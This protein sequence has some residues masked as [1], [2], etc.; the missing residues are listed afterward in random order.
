MSRK[1]S[2]ILMK[3]LR[4]RFSA[5]KWRMWTWQ[6]NEEGS[7]QILEIH[8]DGMTHHSIWNP[9]NER[10]FLTDLFHVDRYLRSSLTWLIEHQVLTLQTRQVQTSLILI[11]EL[12]L[13]INCLEMNFRN[14]HTMALKK[15]F[16]AGLT[17][18]ITRTWLI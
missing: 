15:M 1:W 11:M 9:Q 2:L 17:L 4:T 18:T 5:I 13:Q 10:S 6:V 8:Q 7:F 12:C 14:N 3:P 16:F